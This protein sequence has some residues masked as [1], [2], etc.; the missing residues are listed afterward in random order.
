[1]VRIACLR[2]PRFAVGAVALSGRDC[3]LAHW[4]ALPI[5]LAEHA[6][7]RAVT[8]AAARSGVRT[9]MTVVQGKSKCAALDVLPWDH[10]AI[11]REVARASAA[12]LAASP[13][14]S[15][16]RDEPGT[17]WIGAEGF[18][19]I[20][21]ER[22]LAT[23]LLALA[24]VWHPRARVAIADRCVTAYAATW[25]T[26]AASE[27]LHVAPG[28]DRDYLARVPIALIPMDAELREALGA[29]GLRTAGAFAALD[30]L[31]VERRWGSDGLAAWRL[32]CGDDPRRAT[33]ARTDD[34]R[35]IVHELATSA[36]TVEPVLFLVRAAL[37]HLVRTLAAD[38]LAAAALSITL[39]LDDGRRVTRE[40]R[41]AR[42]I[43]RV[44]PLFERCRAA[45]D[46]WTLEAPIAALELRVC[47]TAAS[48]A[49]Q[50][51]LLA[52][53][54]RDPSAAEAALARLRATLGAGTVVRPIAR[55]SHAPERAGGWVD[56]EQAARAVPL[57]ALRAPAV[58]PAPAAR[59]LEAPEH[60]AVTTDKSGLPLRLFWK[61]RRL[62]LTRADGPERLSG[63][64][65]QAQPFARDYWRCE[66][67][68]LG[69][70]LLLYRDAG[71]WRLQGWYD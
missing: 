6:R 71:G 5:A 36:P 57:D 48:S 62:A 46:T 3:I 11:A 25:S 15:P 45:L 13:Q 66:C 21:G 9:G 49:E 20:G 51:D 1:M 40:V 37:D 50:G 64:W 7:L 18:E 52:A 58:R 14:V 35:V 17:W 2:I 24:R 56:V 44:L 27:P 61:G 33:L 68:E 53:A 4:D 10:G 39:T 65:W 28:G 60:V 19:A 32:A 69:Q 67:D 16:L 26:R 8:A 29:L 42:P 70:D 47:E 30:P 12:F 54:W 63:E 43:A 23:Q 38:G 59:L 55:D 34:P 31:E 41:P 22:V